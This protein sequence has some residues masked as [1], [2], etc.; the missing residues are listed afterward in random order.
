MS[1]YKLEKHYSLSFIFKPLTCLFCG[2]IAWFLKDFSPPDLLGKLYIAI[3]FFPPSLI[4]LID[5]IYKACKSP[6][7]FILNFN[8]NKV[9]IDD[10]FYLIEDL[11]FLYLSGRNDTV[12]VHLELP[13]IELFKPGYSI[14]TLGLYKLDSSFNSFNNAIKHVKN[15]KT[16]Q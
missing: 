4:W 3:C 16:F 11:K 5:R 12:S 2:L 15:I 14:K 9:I 10:K 8:E 7:V 1:I 13:S 6:K